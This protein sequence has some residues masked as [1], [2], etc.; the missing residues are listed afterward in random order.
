MYQFIGDKLMVMRIPTIEPLLQSDYG[1]DLDC[2]LT[3][4]TC[5]LHYVVPTVPIEA[6]YDIVETHASRMFYNGDKWGTFP[7]FIRSIFNLALK[8]LNVKKRT[9]VS[10]FAGIYTFEDI[11]KQIDRMNPVVLSVWKA[12]RYTDHTITVIGYNP[13]GKILLVYDNWDKITH[14][15]PFNEISF[16]SCI[17]W[18]R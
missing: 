12:G 5:V 1:K 16:I 15:L 6:I 10:Y 11:K 8:D 14:E 4:L 2:T 3:S 18:I 13:E 17:N 7:I 9:S